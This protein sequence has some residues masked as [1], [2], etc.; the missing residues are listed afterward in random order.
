MPA[1]PA[2]PPAPA[3]A[4]PWQHPPARTLGLMGL[5]SGLVSALWYSADRQVQVLQPIASVFLLEAGTLPVGVFFALAI[6]SAM[7]LWVRPLWVAAAVAFVVTLY[8]WSFAIHTA[9]RLQRNRDD[10]PH[11]I[12]ASLCA[13]VVG[14]GLTQLGCSVFVRELR[15]PARLGLTC[16]VGAAVGMLLY[17][18]QRKYVDDRLLFVIWQPAVAFA[19]G[20]G[21]GRSAQ[22]RDR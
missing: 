16:L 11:L 7:R 14:A 12:A 17:L 6:A 3:S 18:G 21:I 2:S 4:A 20:L 5:A 13:G 15:R 19:I 8:A 10:D 9:I 1:A 22:S